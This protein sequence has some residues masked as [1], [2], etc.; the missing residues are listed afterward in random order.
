[1]EKREEPK[2]GVEEGVPNAGVPKGE[3]EGWAEPNMVLVFSAPS[4]PEFKVKG[5][6]DAEKVFE[7]RFV[8][9]SL[10]TRSNT[11]Y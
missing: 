9:F 5:A 1:M 6:L 10:H 2:A 11:V 3:E 7:E 4:T 8:W